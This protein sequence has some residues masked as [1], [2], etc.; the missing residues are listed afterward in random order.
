MLDESA[1]KTIIIIYLIFIG[2]LANAQ[3][4]PGLY[5]TMDL[6]MELCDHKMKLMN[7]ESLFCLSGEPAVEVNLFDRVEELVYDSVAQMRGFSIILTAK[8]KDFI[9]TLARK[10]PGHDLGLVV[11]GMLVS[12]IELEGVNYPG[13]IVIWD[14]Y[15]SQAMEWLHGSLVRSV[16]RYNKKS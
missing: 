6:D 5:L 15:D 13:K 1:M 4:K 8:G 11:N 14:Q 16:T 3:S 12:I 7:T 10:L 2:M 9:S